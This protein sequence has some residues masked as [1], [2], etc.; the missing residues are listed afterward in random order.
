MNTLQLYKNSATYPNYDTTLTA[1]L[2][3]YDVTPRYMDYQTGYVDV[4]MTFDEVMGCNY[5]GFTKDGKTVYGYIT[6]VEERSGDKLYRIFYKVDAWRTF[7]DHITLGTQWIRRGNAATYLPDPLLSSVQPY[8]DHSSVVYNWPNVGTRYLVVQVREEDHSNTPLQPSPYTF[9]CVAYTKS[10]W[11]SVAAIVN[12]IEALGDGAKTSNI[13]TMYSVPYINTYGMSDASI[14]PKYATESNFMTGTWTTGTP[15]SGFKKMDTYSTHSRSYDIAAHFTGKED[16]MRVKHSFLLVTPD[17]GIMDIPDE[18]AFSGYLELQQ[19]VDIYSGAV[20]YMLTDL[21]SGLQ[22]PFHKSIRG[23]G[24]PSIPILSNNMDSYLSQNQSALVTSLIGDVAMIGGGIAATATGAGAVAGIPML[25]A[26][27]GGLV[28][29][30]G[31]VLDAGNKPPS[32]PPAMLGAALA[33]EFDNQF[34]IV[35]IWQHVDNDTA[36]HSK[37]GYPQNT[38]QTLVFPSSGFVQTRDCNVK[39]DGTVPL[40]AIQEIN[41][42]FDNGIEVG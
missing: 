14:T 22:K 38:M 30:I 6:N 23:G 25:A 21:S 12:L 9:Y 27:A 4:Q 20:N 40:W 15:I 11:T 34:W 8:P 26:G 37:N 28:G 39:S 5:L 29:T 10:S 32:N 33:A 19:N 3:A 24:F 18:M 1:Y 42:M 13:V 17:A 35:E 7:K 2:T 31:N 41:R 36:V 16:K